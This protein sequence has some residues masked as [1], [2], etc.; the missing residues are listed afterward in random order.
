MI[1]LSYQS[2]YSGQ[3]IDNKLGEIDNKL[4]T[5]DLL[6]KV[7]PIGSIYLAYNHTSPASLFGGTWAR[8]SQQF[9]WAASADG[10]IGATG[11][12]ETHI[13]TIN[14]IPSHTHTFTGSSVTTSSDG[15]HT[16]TKGTMN[17]TGTI[18]AVMM[19]DGLTISTSGAFSNTLA[20]ERSWS[21]TSGS[22]SYKISLNAANNWSGE[23]SS[24][25]AHTHTLTTAGSNSSTGEGAAHNNM[26]PYIQVSMWRRTA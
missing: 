5:S 4:N 10:T 25:G 14:E 19:D 26:P 15:A 11:G 3:E 17:I 12:A 9:L 21:G 6:D 1:L 16:H 23:T 8:I 18:N 22:A 2:K 24:G 13:L 20:R 7:Y